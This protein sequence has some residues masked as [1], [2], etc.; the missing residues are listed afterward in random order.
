M[1]K[2][3]ACY[4]WVLDEADIVVREDR[5]IDYS[6]ARGRISDYDRQAVQAAVDVA[7]DIGGTTV[8]LT[9][10]SESARASLKDVL[11]RGMD[12]VHFV[13]GTEAGASDGLVTARVLAAAIRQIDDV[14]LVVLGDGSADLLDR[15]VGSR[16]AAILDWPIVTAVSDLGLDGEGL[17][18][19][20][21]LED[22]VESVRVPLPAVVTVLPEANQPALPGLKAIMAAKKKPVM[23][24]GI[25]SLDVDLTPGTQIVREE[26]FVME[27]RNDVRKDG[28]PMEKAQF[29]RDALKKEGIL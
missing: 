1:P 7:R 18:A 9:L 6:R 24:I 28:T 21:A 13:T 17:L 12:E 22:C 19:R 14:S 29:L 16:L 8:G 3:V 15:Q 27:R 26:G 2:V 5:S 4:K 11:A 10:G 25:D 23:E 20:R